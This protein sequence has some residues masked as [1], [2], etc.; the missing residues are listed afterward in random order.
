MLLTIKLLKNKI[1]FHCTVVYKLILEIIS[2]LL[3]LVSFVVMFIY[4]TLVFKMSLNCEVFTQ[5]HNLIYSNLS[6]EKSFL[7]LPVHYPEETLN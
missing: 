4:T 3:P 1:S 7:S 2:L 5:F 6:S